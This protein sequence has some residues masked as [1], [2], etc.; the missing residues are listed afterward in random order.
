MMSSFVEFYDNALKALPKTAPWLNAMR[1]KARHDFVKRGLPN[2]SMEAWK[3]TSLDAF[4]EARFTLSSLASLDVTT[5]SSTTSRPHDLIAGLSAGSIADAS[6]LDPADKPRGVVGEQLRLDETLTVPEGVKVL[7]LLEA[8]TTEQ[9]LVQKHLNSLAQPIDGFMTLNNASFQNG[10]LIYVPKNLAIEAPLWLRHK[11]CNSDEGYAIRHLIILEDGA[12]LTLVE[13]YCGEEE[14]AYWMNTASEIFLSPNANLTHYKV[15]RDGSKSFHTGHT[16]VKLNTHSEYQSHM[17]NLS[18]G[19]SRNDLVINLDA[20][21]A[22]CMMNGLYLTKNKAYCDYHTTVHHHV[23][24]CESEQDYKGILCDKSRAVFNGQ[25][26]VAKGADKTVAK[27]QN[28]NLLLSTTAEMDT[29]PELQIYADDVICTHGAT[30]GQLDNDALFYLQARGLSP[31][32]ARQ[33]LIEAFLSENLAICANAMT[34]PRGLS[35]GSK[36]VALSLDPAD[37]PR[38]VETGQTITIKDWLTTLVRLQ[39]QKAPS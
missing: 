14:E 34:T 24:F 5:Y 7:P 31:D 17:I 6:F 12:S 15:Q 8:M 3:Y 2:K 33:C 29:K 11:P 23:G 25:V 20:P 19:F 36:V 26:V 28:K 30:V 13:D 37:K 9:A 38:D 35:A 10:L 39:L 21:H 1:E 4:L 18:A 22:R 27:Q 16:F 32:E